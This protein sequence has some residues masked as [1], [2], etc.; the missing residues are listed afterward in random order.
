MLRLAAACAFL[1]AGAASPQ[2]GNARFALRPAQV[3]LAMERIQLP[4]RRV[5]V[6]LAAAVTSSSADTRLEIKSVTLISPREMRLRIVCSDVS[7]CLPFFALATYPESIDTAKL[8]LQLADK[9]AGVEQAVHDAKKVETSASAASTPV[10]RS[11]SPATLDLDS[12]KVHVSIAVVCLES[13]AAGDKVRVAT[14]D[15]KLVYVAEVVNSKLLK[16]T[17]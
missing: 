12:N 9:A 16:G 1:C 8:P 6:K 17:F 10:M 3:E 11:G 7:E 15:H 5:Q 14:R 2:Q 4:T 13:G